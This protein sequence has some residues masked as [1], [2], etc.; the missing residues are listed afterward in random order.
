MA[1]FNLGNNSMNNSGKVNSYFSDYSGRNFGELVSACEPAICDVSTNIDVSADGFV[2]IRKRN[3]L[4]VR[5]RQ[6]FKIFRHV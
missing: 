2:N 5:R 6:V 4:D 1:D 3:Q